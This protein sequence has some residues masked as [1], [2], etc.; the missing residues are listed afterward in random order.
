[1]TS[2]PR[3]LAV[4]FAFT[5]L[6][7]LATPPPP[8]LLYQAIE[9]YLGTPYLW[10]GTDPERGLDC[11]AFVRLV[12]RKLGVPLPRTSRQQYASLPRVTDEL[13]PGDLLFFSENGRNITHVAIYLGDGYMAHSALSRGGVVIEPAID[14]KEIYVAAARPLPPR[15]LPALAGAG[16][17]RDF[18]TGR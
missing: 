18:K 14:F 13:L 7:A 4:A 3:Q 8:R 6:F 1:M 12:Y 16:G 2:Y 10:G 5:F 15:R 11:S 9:P 17:L